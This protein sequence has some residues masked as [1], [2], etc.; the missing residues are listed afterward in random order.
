MLSGRSAYCN[1][2]CSRRIG[3]GKKQGRGE[4]R[5]LWLGDQEHSFVL[6]HLA[7]ISA[8]VHILVDL[9]IL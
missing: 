8:S 4:G 6:R 9:Q 1:F 5:A 7:S 3:N 2:S